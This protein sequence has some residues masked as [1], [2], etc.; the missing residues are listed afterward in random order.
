MPDSCLYITYSNPQ[1]VYYPGANVNGTV[2]LHLKEPIKARSLKIVVD[3][4]AHTHWNITRSRRVRNTDGTYRTENYTVPYHATVIYAS[5]ETNAWA[6]PPGA[7]EVLPAGS[8]QFPFTFLLPPTCAPSF[9]GSYGYIR[10]MVKVELDRPWRFNKTDKKLFTVVPMFDLNAIPQAVMPFKGITV[11]NLG[12]ILFRHGKVTVEC[13]LPKMGFVPGEMVVIN[14][15]VINDSSKA[16]TKA[17]VKL[18]QYSRYVA[19][20]HGS[21]L[22]QCAFLQESGCNHRELRRKL[23]TGDQKLFI[24]KKSKGQAQI[25]LQ[26]PP[27]VPSFNTCPIVSVEYSVEVKFDTSGALNSDVEASCPI[28]VGTIPVR[29]ANFTFEPSAPPLDSPSTSAVGPSAPPMDSPPPYP[30]GSGAA[31]FPTQPP[32]YEECVSGVDGTTMDTDS[33]EPFAPRYPYYPSLSD[34]GEKNS[35]P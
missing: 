10:Y 35:V 23:A 2:H 21:T 22:P 24:D 16:I 28:I 18:L 12:V 34:N 25:Y 26:V 33:M 1:A 4:R 27:T 32:S 6:A 5:G 20:A 11:K 30:E 7:K 14:A 9:E 3:G 17:H 15:R 19:Y 13:E 31:S 29:S 8:N